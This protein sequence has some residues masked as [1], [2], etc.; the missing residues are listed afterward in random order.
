M[1]LTLRWR[2]S[3][4]LPVD[5]SPIKPETFR[6]RTST[7]AARV[8]LR[9]GNSTAEI[10]DLFVAE[11]DP[12]DDRLVVEGDLGN[13][14]AI[15]RAMSVG[16]LTVRGDVGHRFAAE[17]S[18]GL[19]ELD[20]ARIP[21]AALRDRDLELFDGE[22]RAGSGQQ[23]GQRCQNGSTHRVLLV[24]RRRRCADIACSDRATQRAISARR[25][26]RR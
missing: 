7:D 25:G 13:V 21:E 5:G 24:E 26:V 20:P 15:G 22:A 17:M 6:G 12:G 16:T 23:N 11:G 14:S 9:V 2:A 10:G 3:T 8:R 18:G 1:P 19:A 4:D